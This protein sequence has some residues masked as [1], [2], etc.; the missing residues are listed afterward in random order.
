MGKFKEAKEKY[1]ELKNLYVKGKL[2]KEEFKKELHKLIIEDERGVKWSIGEK[3]GKWYFLENGKWIEGIPEEEKMVECPQ[4]GFQNLPGSKV[5][6][7]CGYLLE[8]KELRCPNCKSIVKSNYNYCPYCGYQMGKRTLASVKDLEIISFSI[9]SLFIFFGGIGI[10]L[11][12][13]IGAYLGVSDIN[14]PLLTKLPNF[15][16]TIRH[17]LKGGMLY[18][19]LGAVAGFLLVGIVGII[20]ASIYNFIRFLFNGIV[21]RVKDKA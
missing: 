4:C 3:S 15:F 8:K 9:T 16:T 14:F 5:C 6:A 19:I 21:F 11:G 18:G 2:S 20:L 13:I 1:F 7:K 10:F 12:I 17:G